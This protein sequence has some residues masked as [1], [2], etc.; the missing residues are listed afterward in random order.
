MEKV[1]CPPGNA[2]RLAALKITVRTIDHRAHAFA[3]ATGSTIYELKLKIRERLGIEPEDINLLY[4]GSSLVNDHTL[5]YYNIRNESV[6]NMLATSS[7]IKS[8]S[9]NNGP[10]SATNQASQDSQIVTN[11]LKQLTETAITRREER[12]KALQCRS[13]GFPLLE[14]ESLEVVRQNLLTSE[15]LF[16]AREE[17]SSLV[18]KTIVVNPFNNGRRKFEL[19]QWVDVKDTIDQW[20]EAEVIDARE[21]Q[22]KIHYNG[23]GA[24]WDEWIE[25]SSPRISFFRN[26]TVQP[27][28]TFYEGNLD[29]VQGLHR[30]RRSKGLGRSHQKRGNFI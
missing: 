25:M 2:E 30:D 24:R 9:P 26:K 12:L 20:L 4:K 11:I 6:V 27:H 1:E 17:Q 3:L 10:F 14:K 28:T 23:W 7:G 22:V 29:F 8:D 13:M 18:S 15:Q 16:A 5:S 19:G 21:D